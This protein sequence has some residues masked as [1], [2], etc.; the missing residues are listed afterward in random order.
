MIE[1][2]QASKYSKRQKLLAGRWERL[3]KHFL[4]VAPANSI[5]RCSRPGAPDD[6]SQ[7][8][9]LHI[10]ATILTAAKTLERVAPFLHQNKTLFKAPR[11][12]Q[13][14]SR[15][16]CGLF[17]GFSQVGKFITVY[18]RSEADAISIA[19]K[20]DQLTRNFTAPAIP[21]DRRFQN[22]RCIFYRFGSFTGI[23][24]IVNRDGS[25]QQAIRKGDGE[26]VADQ[27]S[28]DSAVPDWL[29][30]PFP[31]PTRIR[32]NTSPEFLRTR[33][34]AFEALSQRGKGGVYQALNLNFSPA[35]LCVLKEGRRHGET[36]WDGRDGFWRVKHEAQ[37]LSALS[38]AGV[39]VPE[40]YLTFKSPSHYYL[41]TEFIEGESVQAYLSRKGKA[42]TD[43]EALRIGCAIAETVAQIHAAGWVWRD[44]KPLNFLISQDGSIRPVDF[45]GA[46]R[47]DAPDVMPWGTEAYLPPEFRAF[48][49]MGSR[50]PEDLYAL[51]ATLRQLLR[52]RKLKTEIQPASEKPVNE[53]LRP[54]VPTVVKQLVSALMDAEAGSRPT[55]RHAAKVLAQAIEELREQH[56]RKAVNKTRERFKYDYSSQAV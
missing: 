49:Q 9:K 27:R 35:R 20:L 30:D 48:P 38:V 10:S 52:V 32:R 13:E 46:C 42:L 50:L 25:R 17:Y 5:W 22:S 3:C 47:V 43:L 44:C 55:A 37:V 45:E 54:H 14:L 34:R 4:P 12:L 40:L 26:L 8:W 16:N 56:P 36:D 29:E 53:K 28:P 23:E 2:G 33:I 19:Y 24:E 7:G 6:P 31:R 15:L 18:P 51:G 39:K 11:D 1:P 41:V 21:Y